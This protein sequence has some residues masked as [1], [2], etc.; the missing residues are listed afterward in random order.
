MSIGW[1][2]DIN[3]IRRGMVNHTFGRVRNGGTKPHQGWDFKA[4]VGT[5]CYAIADGA[6]AMIY[7]SPAYGKVLV[8]SFQHEGRSLYAAYAHLSKINVKQGEVVR[9]GSMIALTGESGN[10]SQLPDPLDKHLHFEIRTMPRPGLG[11]DGRLS[12]LEVFGHC[13]LKAAVAR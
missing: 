8:C 1:P 7:D 11:L 12:P 9:R 10:A 6:V 5:P 2:L 3:V 13:P 4:A